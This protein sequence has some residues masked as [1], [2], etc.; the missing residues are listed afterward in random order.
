M[1][2]FAGKMLG[3]QCNDGQS[4]SVNHRMIAVRN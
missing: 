3:R 1:I 4:P 2:P